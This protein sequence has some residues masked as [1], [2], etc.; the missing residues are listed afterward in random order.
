[1]TAAVL[2]VNQMPASV[3]EAE[4]ATLGAMLIEKSG[5]LQA[6]DLLRAEDFYREDHRLIFKA[7]TEVF[8]R[9][10]AVD[11]VTLA[12]HM[13]RHNN[14]DAIA[15]DTPEL[16]GSRYFYSLFDLVSHTA[17]TSHYATLVKEA[18]L[19][20]QV[21]EQIKKTYI[22]KSPENLKRL[23]ELMD[24]LHSVR[25]G[26][27]F[28]FRTDLHAAL[29]DLEKRR[30]ELID[31]G[32][33]S[34]DKIL[35][36]LNAG[37]LTTIG[38]RTSGGKTAFMVKACLQIAERMNVPCLYITTEMNEQQI[39]ERVLPIAS[40]VQAWKF[41][42]RT[43]E[44]NDWTRITTACA[45][46]LSKMPIKVKGKTTLSIGDIRNLISREKPRV[47]FVDYL[48][49]C[50]FPNGDT[51]A[52]Q[53]MDFMKELKTLAQEMKVNIFI[54]CQLNRALDV[55]Q[56]REP[57]NSDLKDSGG[58]EAESDQVIL[59][60]KLSD[61]QILKESIEVKHG[62]TL[63][64]AKISKNRHGAAFKNAD[65]LLNGQYVDMVEYMTEEPQRE[66]LN[67]D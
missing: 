53:V 14:L 19:D 7:I 18:S 23:Q 62:M 40:G 43:F 47:V 66:L 31:L 35:C 50:V 20:R 26:R 67:N 10:E 56:D 13:R 5:T 46:K 37:D 65:L 24:A 27:A 28:D 30:A 58:I 41:R 34:I 29:E 12:E 57:E 51:R 39:V 2:D 22:E 33:P 55:S 42:K 36:G 32:F 64:R 15:A 17:F 11:A 6:L 59:L 54:G 9:D 49:R 52:Y 3:I 44:A 48:Q 8:K 38:A 1:M 45:D 21:G 4:K 60:W 63:V 61:R 16:T 25:G